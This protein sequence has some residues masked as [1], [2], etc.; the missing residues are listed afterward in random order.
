VAAAAAVV[1][2]PA[3]ASAAEYRANLGDDRK[4]DGCAVAGCTLREAVQAA[5]ANPGSDVVLVDPRRRYVLGLGATG[6]EAAATGD[7]DVTDEVAVVATRRRRATIDAAGVDRAFDLLADTELEGIAITNGRAPS[8]VG[9]EGSAIRAADARLTLRDS[10][11]AGNDGPD[12][13]IA[14]VGDRG[15]TARDCEI[16]TNAG[17]GI[18]DHGGGG[19]RIAHSTVAGNGATGIQGLGE[20]SIGVHHSEVSENG[21][22]GVHELDAGDV[23]L[24]D[25]KVHA[26]GEQGAVEGGQGGLYARRASVRA[27]GETALEE[28]GDGP[29]SGHRTRVIANGA[30]AALESDDGAAGFKQSRIA[31]NEGPAIDESGE[32]SVGLEETTVDGGEAGLI[33]RDVGSVELT[34]AKVRGSGGDGVVE[35]GD[36][37]VIFTRALLRGNEGVGLG[38]E[39]DG[40]IARS[41]IVENQGGIEATGG[42]LVIARSSIARNRGAIGG[43]AASAGAIVALNQT[44]V[45]GNAT[46][47]DGG[48][49]RLQASE[50]DSVNSTIAA[51]TADGGGGGIQADAD[52]VLAMNA[53]TVARN[54][55]D[56]DAFG[57]EPGGGVALEAGGEA[58]VKNSLL[59][60]NEAAGTGDDCS[61]V[62]GSGGGNLLGDALACEGFGQIGDQVAAEPRIGT[63]KV[64]GGP[65]ATI[66]LRARSPAIGAA[67]PDAPE[68]DQRNVR[69]RDPDAG[70]F[71]RR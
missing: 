46:T 71:E 6:E 25:T 53:N 28:Q 58:T 19:V 54:R 63:L 17:S 47:T 59:A 26:N 18:V 10:R 65:T 57:S 15:M 30:G 38:I 16:V 66:A 36:G 70:A 42:R 51:N 34:I 41:R 56:A 43:I 35:G 50:L 21:L 61:G 40:N 44:T 3:G 12:S 13:A 69:R 14:L 23:A 39:G 2:A 5:N 67:G 22:R 37:V 4:P 45:A 20:G 60:L 52:S 7:L 8:P 32:G 49:L 68:R 9:A 27:N 48:G 64:N 31:R 29:L 1:A 33:E 24:V 55:A 62:F 11:V